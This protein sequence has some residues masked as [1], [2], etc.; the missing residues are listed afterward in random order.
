MNIVFCTHKLADGGAERVI[1]MWAKGFVDQGHKVNII[2]RNSNVKIQYE[3]PKGVKVYYLNADE[4]GRFRAFF[5]RIFKL[6]QL[7][8]NNGSLK[9][10]ITA[11][12]LYAASQ[13]VL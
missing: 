4:K 2:I 12:R 3:L 8:N 10:E 6:R 9:F 7:L 5:C 11:K 1:S 13:R